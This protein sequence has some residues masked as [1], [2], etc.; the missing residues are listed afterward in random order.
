MRF[1][2]SRAG[3]RCFYYHSQHQLQ[4]IG[5]NDQENG[6]HGPA[7]RPYPQPSHPQDAPREHQHRIVR[8]TDTAP[9]GDGRSSSPC[10]VPPTPRPHAPGRPRSPRTPGPRSRTRSAGA[11]L[12]SRT[13]AGSPP[14]RSSPSLCKPVPA[15]VGSASSRDATR[16]TPRAPAGTSRG[17]SPSPGT[18]PCVPPCHPGRTSPAHAGSPSGPPGPGPPPASS[19]RPS[20]AVRPLLTTPLTASTHAAIVRHVRHVRKRCGCATL[21]R[22][23]EFLSDP[24]CR[25][26]AGGGCTS[27]P[28]VLTVPGSSRPPACPGSSGSVAAP[29]RVRSRWG[30]RTSRRP[31]RPMVGAVARP[32]HTEYDELS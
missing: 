24:P 27:R 7:N 26:I 4:V 9:R 11:P 10:S 8:P 22:I 18:D 23:N 21:R 16:P 17:A 13:T 15:A 2:G 31:S 25:V 30:A 3:A 29:D 1:G 28:V 12:R 5:G 32:R 6:A 20:D 19:P 14:H